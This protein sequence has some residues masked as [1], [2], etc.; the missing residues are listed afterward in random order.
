MMQKREYC[1][2]TLT[3]KVSTPIPF[4]IGIISNSLWLGYHCMLCILD[5]STY[6]SNIAKLVFNEFH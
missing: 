2:Y 5:N 3:F 4:G 6:A 1:L